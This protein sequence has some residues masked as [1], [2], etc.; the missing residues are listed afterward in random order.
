M[1]EL[2]DEIVQPTTE[3]VKHNEYTP[4]N[5]IEMAIEKGLSIEHL[6]G[7]MELKEKWDAQQAKLAYDEA[8]A[9][10]QSECPPIKKM[11]KGGVTREGVV[12]YYYAPIEDIVEQT[13]EL[14][15]KYGFSFKMSTVTLPG[16]VEVTFTITHVQGHS[17]SNSVKMPFLTQTGIMSSAQVV[18]GTRTFAMRYAYSDGFGITTIDED[19]DSVTNEQ[20]NILEQIIKEWDYKDWKMAE[21]ATINDRRVFQQFLDNIPTAEQT[22]K[23]KELVKPLSAEIKQKQ[24]VTFQKLTKVTVEGYLTQLETALKPKEK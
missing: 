23:F 9:G 15:F 4:A 5:F 24:W 21:A 19:K 2:K 1:D 22:A 7:L 6:K 10:F 3:I 17:E 13:R 11:K 14:R 12:A 20:Q 18:A 8:M 16:E